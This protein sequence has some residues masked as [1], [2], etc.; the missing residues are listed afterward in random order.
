MNF[1]QILLGAVSSSIVLCVGNFA[2]AEVINTKK[3]LT[4]EMWKNGWH[5]YLSAQWKL[6]GLKKDTWW[7][8]QEYEDS[9][10]SVIS[11]AIADCITKNN[12][13][14]ATFEGDVIEF[15]DATPATMQYEPEHWNALYLY[16]LLHEAMDNGREL[17][18][19]LKTDVL[20]KLSRYCEELV[21]NEYNQDYNEKLKRASED[22]WCYVNDVKLGGFINLAKKIKEQ[23]NCDY[24]APGARICK[25]SDI[26][27]KLQGRGKIFTKYLDIGKQNLAWGNCKDYVV[28]NT[29]NPGTTSSYNNFDVQGYSTLGFTTAPDDLVTFDDRDL[30]NRYQFVL[31][32]NA[33]DLIKNELP[34]SYLLDIKLTNDQDAL[35]SQIVTNFNSYITKVNED[36]KKEQSE[37]NPENVNKNSS[38]K[39]LNDML[40]KYKLSDDTLNNLFLSFTDIDNSDN[41]AQDIFYA[42]EM[43]G[44]FKDWQWTDGKCNYKDD[45]IN[46]IKEDVG[47]NQNLK[48]IYESG[49][50]KSL[51]EYFCAFDNKELNELWSSARC[52]AITDLV[53]DEY[54]ILTIIEEDELKAKIAEY[55]F[56]LATI[57]EYIE[58][59]LAE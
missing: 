52:R 2:N 23:A 30:Q 22:I 21:L 44:C 53:D 14:A 43:Q 59:K 57:R 7:K 29:K 49:V 55:N 20:N 31:T 46:A 56:N 26:E 33:G 15:A 3:A 42:L 24:A 16:N 50:L 6:A 17:N 45:F 51:L 32:Q 28:D 4:R 5:A 58:Q 40:S 9:I 19:D 35:R 25:Y 39:A 8:G 54:N 38:T 47:S 10:F 1:R 27:N 37:Q 36:S 11:E 12:A 41:I 48:N 34:N 13:F 18:E